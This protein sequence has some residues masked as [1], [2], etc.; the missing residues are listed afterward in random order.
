MLYNSNAMSSQPIIYDAVHT[1]FVCTVCQKVMPTDNSKFL[2]HIR[3]EHSSMGSEEIVRL[4]G[5]KANVRLADESTLVCGDGPVPSNVD[6]V[7]RIDEKFAIYPMVDGLGVRD[8]Y[9]CG[10]IS[11]SGNSAVC[12]STYTNPKQLRHHV[13]A[14]HPGFTARQ[15]GQKY[16]VQSY[17][18]LKY[19]R[20]CF[21]VG[22]SSSLFDCA[23][24]DVGDDTVVA[25]EV[26]NTVALSTW[27]H[28]EALSAFTVDGAE[29]MTAGW[30]FSNES[31]EDVEIPLE[32][33][34]PLA[35]SDRNCSNDSTHKVGVSG[36]VNE[37]TVDGT[38]DIGGVEVVCGVADGM[39]GFGKS[40]GVASESERADAATGCLDGRLSKK[41]VMCDDDWSSGSDDE[42]SFFNERA[43]HMELIR[44]KNSTLW[45]ES[46][47]K[48]D[49]KGWVEHIGAGP[50]MAGIPYQYFG[51]AAIVNK[52]VVE[53]LGFPIPTAGRLVDIVDEEVSYIAAAVDLDM[54]NEVNLIRD[55]KNGGWTHERGRV[56]A[57]IPVEDTT[58]KRVFT[59]H[60]EDDTVKKYLRWWT[61]CMVYSWRMYRC[62]ADLF[63]V[64][65]KSESGPGEILFTSKQEDAAKAV[66]ACL[67]VVHLDGQDGRL[68]LGK[69]VRLFAI[70]LIESCIGSGH[71]RSVLCSYLATCA[72]R[73]PRGMTGALVYWEWKDAGQFTSNI[74]GVVWAMRVIGFNELIRAVPDAAVMPALCNHVE[75][76][77]SRRSESP[78]SVLRSWKTYCSRADQSEGCGPVAKWDSKG[79]VV[80]YKGVELPVGV[81]TAIVCREFGEARAILRDRLLF[82]KADKVVP[83]ESRFMFDDLDDCRTGKCFV[84]AIRNSWFVE[85]YVENRLARIV[86]RDTDLLSKF[87]VDGSWRT[88]QD[89]HEHLHSHKQYESDVQAF[90]R[91]LVVAIHFS[92]GG[93]L[94][95]PELLSIRWRNIEGGNRRHIFVHEHR[96]MLHTTY[97]KSVTLSSRPTD[98]IHFLPEELGNLLLNF[99]AYV[100]PF[101]LTLLQSVAGNGE[102]DVP[103]HLF[104]GLWDSPG[105][106]KQ[107]RYL[108]QA[109]SD[110]CVR[111]GQEPIPVSYWRQLSVAIARKRLEPA[112]LRRDDH[113]SKRLCTVGGLDMDSDDDMFASAVTE[114][115]RERKLDIFAMQ[116]K[117]SRSVMNRAYA[118]NSP[119]TSG[120]VIN[121]GMSVSLWWHDMFELDSRLAAAVQHG[122]TVAFSGVEVVA[123]DARATYGPRLFSRR[124]LDKRFREIMG[125]M[126][127]KLHPEG[128]VEALK[129]LCMSSQAEQVVLIAGTGFGKSMTYLLPASMPCARTTIVVVPLVVLRTELEK[130]ATRLGITYCCFSRQRPMYLQ[131]AA[132]VCVVTDDVVT[133]E[134]REYAHGLVIRGRL[135]RIVVDECHML[136][137]TS[138][139]RACFDKVG[140]SVRRLRAQTL[141]LTAT[142]PPPLEYA[143][144]ARAYLS[145]AHFI[146]LPS[147]RPNIGYSVEPV[148]NL[149][150]VGVEWLAERVWTEWHAMKRDMYQMDSTAKCIVFCQSVERVRLLGAQLKAPVF[151]GDVEER[152]EAAKGRIIADWLSSPDKPIIVAS[153]ALGA[154]FDY[155]NVRLVVHDGEPFDF[156][157]FPQETGRA[158]RNGQRS[159]S[160][161]LYD[162]NRTDPYKIHPIVQAA[163]NRAQLL[164]RSGVHCLRGVI[165]QFLDA[166]DEWVWCGP[167][168]YACSVCR[169][170]TGGV[171]RLRRPRVVEFHHNPNRSTAEPYS[172]EDY[173]LCSSPVVGLKSSPSSSDLP[174]N[175]CEGY[176]P[177]DRGCTP[178]Q[179]LPPGLSI[180]PSVFIRGRSGDAKAAFGG[181]ISSVVSWPETGSLCELSP[182]NSGGTGASGVSNSDSKLCSSIDDWASGTSRES[183]RSIVS[184]P[185]ADRRAVVMADSSDC[186]SYSDTKFTGP[187][188]LAVRNMDMA[189]L[190]TRYKDVVTY[191][192]GLCMYCTVAGVDAE[193]TSLECGSRAA[194]DAFKTPF[195]RLAESRRTAQI[196][197]RVVGVEKNHWFAIAGSCCWY[198]Y[199]P[200]FV[201][202]RRKTRKCPGEPSSKWFIF[203]ALMA[204]YRVLGIEHVDQLVG[205][206]FADE[207]DFFMWCGLGFEGSE[208]NG[209]PILNNGHIVVMAVL[210]RLMDSARA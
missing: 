119:V 139:Y 35:L 124:E 210:G 117:H 92:C 166:Q 152:N 55:K 52:A 43:R 185:R 112:G 199:H 176:M 147:R 202:E 25:P 84:D 60:I 190:R 103:A 135:D 110:A 102:K 142:L 45:A 95:G 189:G 98:A 150:K 74:M 208:R 156:I 28:D 165:S 122:Q 44:H 172:L 8:G 136:V 36:N 70:T 77:Y 167:D 149:S 130:T 137:N 3:K 180:P 15:L 38:I 209:K 19:T 4:L 88:T 61:Q 177:T 72:V 76:Y 58:N 17:H 75:R 114:E 192:A 151:F 203:G 126:K 204:V 173:G 157:S 96:V 20:S 206:R 188:V 59:P 73:F 90:L 83:I 195:L 87:A 2:A 105:V 49:R 21:A 193:H 13:A 79:T 29:C 91:H 111:C 200:F 66:Q 205:R 164:Y 144:V 118:Q 159:R 183:R 155:G 178:S 62:C 113:R 194:M 12:G 127:A 129:A 27:C 175:P 78:Y 32:I 134:F 24:F 104:S 80:S 141:W 187:D 10:Y 201:C 11:G 154:G 100:Q 37:E 132:L 48:Q 191:Y 30:D 186:S 158:G 33:V 198:C 41:R 56:M 42:E 71:Y 163:S 69:A 179:T 14:S 121:A 148:R 184:P 23:E 34:E 115:E 161:L 53:K 196:A 46:G 145:G 143:F 89:L 86:S 123:A 106:L 54:W 162:P 107:S 174:E 182:C 207:D 94:R 16:L 128:Q 68:G 57:D 85:K 81:V 125:D 197:K 7:G 31:S 120:E 131:E 146:R 18:S 99:I 9:V 169:N 47:A 108:N 153:S 181:A 171:F 67:K 39:E 133:P 140:E 26:M 170:R 101:R 50:H 138:H 168:D 109:M 82:G 116:S 5:E 51:L 63:P 1:V 40:E 65:L 22:V 97:S 64:E 6:L 160:V 93:P